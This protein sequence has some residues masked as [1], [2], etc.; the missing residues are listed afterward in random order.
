[1]KKA[2]LWAVFVRPRGARCRRAL[3]LGSALYLMVPRAQAQTVFAQ[4]AQPNAGSR[5][6]GVGP[7]AAGAHA[8][9]AASPGLED[10]VVTAQK[11]KQ[12]LYGVGIAITALSGAQ[13]KQQGITTTGQLTKVDSSFVFT[14]SSFGAPVYTLRGIGYNDYSIYASPTVS[15]YSDEIP[16][17]Y[18]ALSKGAT[19]DVSQVEILKG[20]QGTL[21]GQNATGGA[22]NYLAARPT[23]AF[24]AGIEVTYGNFDSAEVDGYIS[25]ALAPTLKARASFDISEGGAYQKSDTRDQ[26]TGA[27]DLKKGRVIFDWTPSDDLKVS[28][29]LNG[30]TDN[31]ETIVGQKIGVDL[32]SPPFASKVPLEFAEP[33]AGQNDQSAD[34]LSGTPPHDDE[35]YF[36]GSIRADYTV[37]DKLLLTYLGTYENYVQNDLY[38]STGSDVPVTQLD[39]GEVIGTY[40]ELRGSGKLVNDKLDWLL[41]ADFSIADTKENRLDDISGQ[42]SSY[43]FTPFGYPQIQDINTVS[44]DVATSGAVFGNLEYHILDNLDV[45]AGARYNETDINHTGC[46]EDVNGDELQGTDLIETVLRRGVGVVPA[47]IDGCTT[48][49]PNLAPELIHQKLNENNAPWRVGVDWTAIKGTLL[50]ATISKGYKAG[51]FTNSPA[52]TYQVLKPAKQEALLAYEAGFKSRFLDNRFEIDGAYFHYDYTDKQLNLRQPDPNGIFGLLNVLIN[53]PKSTEDGVELAARFS[54]LDG[55]VLTAAGTYL[56]TR[57]DGSFINY[58]PLSS[59]PIN[60]GG[61]PFPNVPKWSARLGAQYS[62][63]LSDRFSAFVGASGRYQG[64]SAGAFGTQNDAQLGY[65]SF[66]IRDYAI[67]D[68]RAGIN[69]SDGHWHLEVFGNNVTN[70]Y[71]WNQVVRSGDLID[72]FAG[73][74]TM[75]G[76][77]LGYKFQ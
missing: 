22:V 30:F 55:L 35:G 24:Q 8:P 17:L 52:T 64:K 58:S 77:T 60:I 13:L 31:S 50:Y 41:G 57:V 71:Y 65:P 21:Y 5:P 42:S 38:S 16:Y 54:P 73:L 3:L 62:F 66:E 12:S 46:T 15:V 56:D 25:G 68:L 20:P 32:Q 69:T 18:T 37:S 40:Q 74:P 49:G 4:S 67:L 70:E 27:K 19:L 43:A 44:R 36:Q 10:I 34:W 39:R 2:S 11:R 72:R 59:S 51:V 47:H 76:A 1:M 53:V 48:L 63:D 29:N 75:Y 6:G 45:H 28:V 61:E 23:S 7:A 26:T 14:Q 9:K 33:L